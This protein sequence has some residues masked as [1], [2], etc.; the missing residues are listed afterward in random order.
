[1]KL[2]SLSALALVFSSGIAWA[3]SPPKAALKQKA[4][5]LSLVEQ[6]KKL[7][8]RGWSLETKGLPSGVAGV[9]LGPAT[10]TGRPV[11]MVSVLEGGTQETELA[12]DQARAYLVDQVQA[13]PVSDGVPGAAEFAAVAPMAGTEDR[14]VRYLVASGKP[15]YLL[16]V[17]APKSTFE[18]TY[19]Q[20]VDIATRLRQSTSKQ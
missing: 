15:S 4:A 8:P 17:V 10:D 3:S 1:M 14:L 2:T 18:A 16:T 6:I 11:V 5:R 12:D 7:L 20:V 13:Q 9:A 19:R